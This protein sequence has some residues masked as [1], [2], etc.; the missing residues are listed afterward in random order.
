MVFKIKPVWLGVT[1][2]VLVSLVFGLVYFV[3]LSEPGSAFYLFAGL[4]FLGGSLIGG[5]IAVTI[6]PE[7]QQKTFLTTSVTVFGVVFVLFLIL[8]LVVPQFERAS[9]PLPA[10]CDGFDGNF[11]PPAQLAY[12]LPDQSTGILMIDDQ[13]TAVVA[14]VSANPPSGVNHPPDAKQP[15]FPTQVFIVHKPGNKILQSL[16]FQNDIVSAAIGPGLVYIFNDKLGF[17]F[18][19]HTGN[20]EENFL[21]LD[22]YGGLSPTDRPFL[23][24][25]ASTGHWYLETTAV[26]SSWNIH[27]RV[28]SRPHLTFNG[29]AFGCFI[30]GSTREV[31]RY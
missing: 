15:L 29:I 2:G 10:F 23:L 28:V 16:T 26:I 25:N 3:V 12:T 21:T 11:Q 8:Y 14:R 17:L 22:N 31:I 20:L 9:V 24:S 30:S 18:D 19:A 5:L 6:K 4:T 13:E 1:S 7:H 27:G